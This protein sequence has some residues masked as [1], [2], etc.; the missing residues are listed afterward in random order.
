[1]ATVFFDCQGLLLCEFLAPR[2]TITAERYVK[3]L[4]NLKEAIRKKRPKMWKERSFI[5]HHDNASPHTAAPTLKKLQQWDI[6]TLEHPPS[7]PDLTPC[8]F[9]LFPKLKKELCGHNFRNVASVQRETKKILCKF[10]QS[11]FEDFIFEMVSRWQ[12]CIAVNGDYFEGDNMQ[13]DPLF[14]KGQTSESS[15][16]DEADE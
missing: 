6:T 15:S 13:I 3:T 8:D 14:E 2:D 16:S 4:A 10:P 12:K 1:M 5:L 11:V 7:S 9:S